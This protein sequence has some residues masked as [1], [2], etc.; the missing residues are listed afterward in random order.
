MEIGSDIKAYGETRRNIRKFQLFKS[1]CESI[2]PEEKEFN[3]K[4]TNKALY[5]ICAILKDCII[6][7][8]NF[9]H[10]P[11][12]VTQFLNLILLTYVIQILKEEK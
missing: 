8:T 12:L 7:K 10:K 3:F 2:K 6:S 4:F 5:K 11:Y 9:Y 1:L